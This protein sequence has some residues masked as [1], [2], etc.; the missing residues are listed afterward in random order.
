MKIIKTW[1]SQL[2]INMVEIMIAMLIGVFLVGGLI[3]M[4]IGSKKTYSLQEANARLQENGRFA[5]EFLSQDVHQADFWGCITDNT[6][7]YPFGAGSVGVS[8]NDNDDSDVDV[9]NG[10]DSITLT[11]FKNLAIPVVETG[12]NTTPLI[13]QAGTGDSLG[14]N[15]WAVV[16]NCEYADVFRVLGNS[17]TSI[18]HD[19]FANEYGTSAQIFK[20]YSVTY[21]IR[22]GS[23]GQPALFKSEF[24]PNNVL[25]AGSRQELVE[26]IEDMQILYGEDSDADGIADRYLPINQVGDAA[27]IKGM[28][29]TLLA[30]SGT[31]GLISTKEGITLIYAAGSG[32]EGPESNSKAVTTCPKNSIPSTCMGITDGRV[33]N[34]YDITLAIRNRLK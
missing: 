22:L 33:R 28:R 12:S 32:V 23:N 4:F 7:V 21:D 8:G 26:G 27:N 20:W 9:V 14:V 2:G 6:K 34:V 16:T 18:T 5:I 24:D 10:T 17:G 11:G 19:D 13:I 31:D 15:D 29:I 3:Q 1:R 25:V 30:R